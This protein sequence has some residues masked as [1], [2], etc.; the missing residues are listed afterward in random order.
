MGL[1]GAYRLGRGDILSH[2]MKGKPQGVGAIFMGELTLRDS[3]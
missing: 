2:H 1:E 3:N